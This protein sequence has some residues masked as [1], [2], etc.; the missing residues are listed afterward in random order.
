M[1]CASLVLSAGKLIPTQPWEHGS[2]GVLGDMWCPAS[3]WLLSEL[4]PY[5]G[6]G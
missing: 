4:G 2:V 5:R 3:P 6:A 1:G